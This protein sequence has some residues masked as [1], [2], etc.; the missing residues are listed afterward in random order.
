MSTAT[1]PMENNRAEKISEEEEGHRGQENGQKQ[2][3]FKGKSNFMPPRSKNMFIETYC[4]LVQNDIEVLLKRKQEY[5]IQNNMPTTERKALKELI[6]DPSV[7]VKPCDKGGGICVL[8][9]EDYEREIHRQLSVA[10]FYERLPGNPTSKFKTFINEKLIYYKEKGEITIHE[11]NY[12]TVVHPVTPVFYT[13]PKVHKSLINPPG[14]PIVA[15]IGGLTEKISSF[16][17]TFLKPYVLSLPSFTRDSIDMIKTLEDLPTIGE[18]IILAT[19]DVE[20]LYTMIPH[21]GGLEAIQYF[22]SQRPLEEK[23]STDCICKLAEIVLTCNF[24]LFQNNFYL[25]VNGTAMGSKMA[26]NYANLFV[27]YLEHKIIFNE[28]KNPFLSHIKLYK[29]FVDDILVLYNGTHEELQAFHNFLNESCSCLKFTMEANETCINFL[30]IQIQKTNSGLE[31]NIYRKPT[32]RNTLLRADSFHPTSLKRSLP[33]SQMKRVRR[34]CSTGNTF[35]EQS[36]A[37]MARFRDRGYPED[38]LQVAAHRVQNTTQLESLEPTTRLKTE[39]QVQCI[40][41]Y[42]SLANEIKQVIHKHWHIIQSDPTCPK[43]L[44]ALPRLVYKRPRNIRDS[45]VKADH[46]PPPTPSHFLRPIPNGFYPC[47]RCAQDNFTHKCQTFTHPS[48]GQKI[49]IKSRITCNSINVIYMIKCPCGQAYVGKTCRTLK[50]RISEHRS[51]IRNNNEK[52]PLAVHF[53]K[54]GHT[55]SSLRFIGIEQVKTHRRGGDTENQLLK[56]ECFWIHFLQT[57]AP[58]GL[59]EELD[60]RPFL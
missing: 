36:E 57:L 17:D 20:S 3:V 47:G 49:D 45:I 58:K 35:Q 30:D 43:A 9:T 21:E 27:G 59:N 4:Q 60:I 12:M 55:L 32:D 34:I 48:T 44:Q 11:Y 42:S 51:N 8:D 39:R 38:C 31:T 1:R 15:G 50:T 23:P 26:C 22:L 37:M 13:L 33:I 16:V 54:L 10:R 14:R 25:Q 2:K 7:I 19:F 53:K 29:R 56:R 46:P 18:D 24:F 41:S 6:D 28:N 40:I 52:S 5:K